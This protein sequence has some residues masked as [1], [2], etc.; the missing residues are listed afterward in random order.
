VSGRIG[1]A[2]L[3]PGVRELELAQARMLGDLVAEVAPAGPV[4]A[5]LKSAVDFVAAPG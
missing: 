3:P 2:P 4:N 5:Y 1:V